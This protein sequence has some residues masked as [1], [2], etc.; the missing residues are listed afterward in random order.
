MPEYTLGNYTFRPI[1]WVSEDK[2]RFLVGKPEEFPES[3][4]QRIIVSYPNSDPAIY[5]VTP[6]RQEYAKTY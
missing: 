4:T 6:Q 3:L 5:I 2:D 1:N